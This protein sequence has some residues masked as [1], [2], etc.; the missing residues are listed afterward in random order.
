MEARISNHSSNT[1]VFH[2]AANDYENAFKISG[3]NVKLQYKLTNQNTNNKINCKKTIIWFNPP[4]NK[5]ISTKIDQ[6][7]FNLLDKHFPKNYKSFSN[8]N[9]NNAKVN[10][11]CTKTF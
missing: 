8:F 2:H 7:F 6:Y 5:T 11:N 3:Y 4:F 1:P 9:R 10:Y